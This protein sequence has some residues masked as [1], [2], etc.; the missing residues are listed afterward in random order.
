[1]LREGTHHT[2]THTQSYYLQ[3]MWQ[4]S[5]CLDIEIYFQHG[6]G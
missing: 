3:E 1:M 4:I 2:H 6:G 5:V